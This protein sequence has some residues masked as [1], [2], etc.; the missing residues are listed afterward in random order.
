MPATDDEEH[1]AEHAGGLSAKPRT[2]FAG[3]ADDPE[4][5]FFQSRPRSPEETWAEAE[6]RLA[7]LLSSVRDAAEVAPVEMSLDRLAR[8]HQ[9]IFKST[10]SAEAG[11]LRGEHE[12]ASFTVILIEDGDAR[13]TPMNGAEGGPELRRRLS[14]AC[15]RFNARLKALEAAGG[16]PRVRDAISIAAELYIEILD[17]H[18]FIDGNLRA[19][20]VALEAALRSANLP[21][22]RFDR[23]LERHDAAIGWAIRRDE[24]RTLEPLVSLMED[25]AK[26]QLTE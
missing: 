25:L 5:P 19:A 10:F 24:K 15:E 18:P 20:A 7:R 1:A 4:A 22:I 3:Y 6:Q 12:Q 11:R 9:A 21:V 26:G 23:V 8:W 14:Q 13:R 16:Q 2:G 17:A